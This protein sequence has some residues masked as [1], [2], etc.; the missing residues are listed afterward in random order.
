MPQLNAPI[1]TNDQSLDRVLANPL[2]VILVLSSGSVDALQPT[3]DQIARSEAGKLLVAKVNTSENPGIAQRFNAN[4]GVKLVAWKSGAEQVSL[5][6]PSPD[7]VTAV[8]EHLLGRGPAPKTVKQE[9]PAGEAAHP[10]TVNEASFDQQ[11]LRSSEPVLVD[12]WAPWCGP[13]R[14]VAPTLDKL[15]REYAGK[16]RI[17]KLNVDENPRLAAKYGAHSIPLL[18]LFKDGK[19]FKQLLGAHPEPNIRNL[20]EQALR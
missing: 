7:Q 18:I 20:V 2:P 6:N 4:G 9:D 1:N 11:V 3:L 12:F 14:M 16:I 17:A 10:I 13:C 8:A 15:S 5:D 19:P